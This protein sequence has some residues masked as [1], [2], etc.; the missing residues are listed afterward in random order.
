MTQDKPKTKKEAPNQNLPNQEN[1]KGQKG[2]P[3][4]AKEGEGKVRTKMRIAVYPT[5]ANPATWGHADIMYRASKQFDKVYWVAAK[6]RSKN[7]S[8]TYEERLRFMRAYVTYYKLENVEVELFEGAIARYAK[9]KNASCLIRGLRNT[10]DFQA[11]LELAA[12]NRGIEKSVETICLFAKPHYATISS[13]LVRELAILGEKIDQYV[14]P[15]ISQE[16]VQCL[17]R[18]HSA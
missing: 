18:N 2:G 12:G 10:T 11:E 5:S 9:S 15:S 14:L 7:L 17:Q 3:V 6:N 16:I 1:Q 8:F 4:S 13:H